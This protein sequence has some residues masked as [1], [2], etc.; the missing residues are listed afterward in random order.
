M[1]S[2]FVYLKLT[3]KASIFVD[4]ATGLQ[5]VRDVPARVSRKAFEKMRNNPN[6]E[7][8]NRL[9]SHFV[10]CTEGEYDALMEKAVGEGYTGNSKAKKSATTEE[11]TPTSVADESTED[12]F[13]DMTKTELANYIIENDPDEYSDDVA[14][15]VKKLKKKSHSDLVEMAEEL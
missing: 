7:I 14:A 3:E 13:S 11:P 15:E 8:K 12:D 2:E 6:S 5:I 1:A 4:T 10:Q 9:G